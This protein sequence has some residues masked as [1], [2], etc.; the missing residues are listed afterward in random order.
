MLFDNGQPQRTVTT[1]SI[2]GTLTLAVGNHSLQLR[3]K[4]DS[5]DYGYSSAIS[6]T[7]SA[8]VPNVPP[9]ASWASPTSNITIQAAANG[10]ATLTV[11]GYGAD[12]D[13]AIVL[14]EVV[15]GSTQIAYGNG[16]S[17]NQSVN[18]AVGTHTLRVRATDNGGLSALSNAITVT[19]TPAPTNPPPVVSIVA[20]TGNKL[21]GDRVSIDVTATDD[22]SVASVEFHLVNPSNQDTVLGTVTTG[23]NNHYVYVWNTAGYATGSY[24][25]YAIARDNAGASTKSA[26]P[27]I[28]LNT[29]MGVNFVSVAPTT[30]GGDASAGGTLSA[31]IAFTVQAT[32][33]RDAVNRVELREGE[34]ILKWQTYSVSYSQ[35]AEPYPINTQRNDTLLTNLSVGDHVVYIRA[36]TEN[37]LSKNSDPFTIRVTAQNQRPTVSFIQPAGS[38]TQTSSGP[39]TFTVKGKA[40][41][42]DGTIAGI[43]LLVNGAPPTAQQ[44]PVS[45]MSGDTFEGTLTLD[46]N[47]YIVGLTATDNKGLGPLDPAFIWVNINRPP[48][49]TVTSPQVDQ[50]FKVVSGGQAS[51]RL[52]AKAESPSGSI[53]SLLVKLNGSVLAESG[54]ASFDD[55]RSLPVGDY[56]LYLEATDNVGY[57]VTKTIPFKVSVPVGVKPTV[58]LKASNNNVS[59]A[60]ASV[61]FQGSASDSDGNVVKLELFRNPGSGYEPV[62]VDT[63]TGNAASLAYSKSLTVSAGAYQFMLRATDSQGNYQDSTPVLVNIVNPANQLGGQAQGVRINTADKPELIGWAC[64][65]GVEAGINIQ[66]FANFPSST[67]GTLI[68]NAVANLAEEFDKGVFASCG[69]TTAHRFRIDLSAYTSSFAGA[70]IYAVAQNAAQTQSIVLPCADNTCTMPGSLRIALTTPADQSHYAGKADIFAKAKISNGTGSYDEVKFFFDEGQTWVD[71]VKDTEEGAYYARRTDVSGRTTPYRIQAM[72]RQGNTTLYS[73]ERQ[74]FV[75]GDASTSPIGWTSPSAGTSYQAGANIELAVTVG[76]TT[77]AVASVKFT[78]QN[79][80]SIGD[81]VFSAGA[82][83]YT[84]TAVP[85][86]TYS[87]VATAYATGG[88]EIVTSNKQLTVIPAGTGVTLANLVTPYLRNPD[89]GTL[90]GTLDSTPN[91]AATYEIPLTLPPGTGQMVPSLNLAYSSQSKNGLL[92]IGWALNGLSSI[93]RCSQSIAIDG[94]A[95]AVRFNTADRLCLDGQRLILINLPLSNA[96]Y[97]SDG[98]EYRTEREGFSRILAQVTNGKRSFK[99][100]TK[101][102]QTLFYG[103]TADSYVEGQGRADGLA[104][105]WALHHT[106]D[107]SGNAIDYEYNENASTGEH[108]PKAIRWGGNSAAGLSHY[109]KV[110]F[111]YGTD[112]DPNAE[113]PDTGIAYL[114]GSHVDQRQRLR[115]VTSFT[116]TEPDGSRGVQALQYRLAYDQSPTSYRSRLVS[117]QACDAQDNCLP[118]TQFDWGN[119]S[120]I[121]YVGLGRW[122]GPSIPLKQGAS[123]LL[124]KSFEGSISVV[125]L[126]GDGKSDIVARDG[127]FL[128][129]GSNFVKLQ[130]PATLPTLPYT[131]SGTASKIYMPIIS[132]FDGDGRPELLWPRVSWDAENERNQF[133]ILR[134][135]VNG[136][137]D[138]AT[139]GCDPE[140]NLGPEELF[141]DIVADVDGDGKSEMLLTLNGGQRCNVIGQSVTCKPWRNVD[142]IKARIMSDDIDGVWVRNNVERASSDFDG[143]GIADYMFAT[144]DLCLTG[145]DGFDCNPVSTVSPTVSGLLDTIA[146]V[147]QTSLVVDIN[148]DGYLDYPFV[149]RSQPELGTPRGICYGTGTSLDCRLTTGGLPNLNESMAFGDAFGNGAIQ[150]LYNAGTCS[151]FGD[152]FTCTEGSAPSSWFTSKPGIPNATMAGDFT[153]EGRLEMATYIGGTDD[154]HWELFTPNVDDGLDRIVRVKNGFGHEQRAK[155]ASSGAFQQ[156]QGKTYSYP[157]RPIANPGQLVSRLQFDYG[158]VSGYREHSYS[159]ADAA[160]DLSGRGSVGMASRTVQLS[161]VAMRTTEVYRQDWPYVGMLQHRTVMSDGTAL[162]ETESTFAEKVI[163]QLHGQTSFVYVASSV[164]E[165][166]DYG[167]SYV[168]KT[169]TTTKF[170][171][172]YGNPTQVDVLAVGAD[173]RQ[174]LTRTING[175][176]NDPGTWRLGVLRNVALTKQS[177]A[178]QQTRHT[179]FE[180]DSKGRLY[181]ETIEPGNVELQL[182]TVY[183]RDNPVGLIS[184][185]TQYWRDPISSKDKSRKLNETGYD[186][187]YRF[188]VWI[189]NALDHIETRT[190]DSRT[191]VQTSVTDSNNVTT[192]WDIDGFG[193]RTRE[194]RAAGTPHITETFYY[195]KQCMAACP[196]SGAN[197]VAIT[198][199]YKSTERIAVPSLVFADKLG[200]TV[201][202]QSWGFDGREIYTQS[203]FDSQD[204]VST[205]YQPFFKGETPERGSTLSYDQLNRIQKTTTYDDG[206]VGR[207][208]ITTYSGPVTAYENPLKQKKTEYRNIV[209]QLEKVELCCDNAGTVI[210]TKYD[211]DAFGNL[212]TVTDHKG[213]AVTVVYDDLGRK[214]ELRDPDLGTITYTVD[215]LGQTLKQVSPTQLAAG[216]STRM[217]FDDLGRMTARYDE[218]DLESHWVYGQVSGGCAITKSCGQVVE[219]YTGTSS[220]KDYIRTH[221]YEDLGRPKATTIKFGTDTYTSTTTYDNRGLVTQQ[222]QQRGGSAAK[223]FDFKYNELGYQ[224]RIERNGSLLW[225]STAQ[226]ASNRVVNAALGNRLQINRLF[227][228][229]SGRLFEADLTLAPDA[230]RLKEAYQYDAVGNVKQ[231][232][233][234]WD[235]GGFQELFNYDRINRLEYSEV[236]GQSSQAQTF[237][238]NEIGNIV[239]KTG[240]GTGNYVY[241]NSGGRLPHA[242]SSV[243]GVGTFTY[244]QNGNLTEGAGRTLCWN[245]FDMPRRIN[246]GGSSCDDNTGA[247]SSFVYGPEHQ[248]TRQHKSD[249]TDILYAGAMEVET[250]NGNDTV[251]TYWPAGLGVEIDEPG[252]TTKLNWTHT[253]RLGSVIG[254]SNESGDLI[255]RLAYDAWGKRRNLNGSVATDGLDGR[256]DNKGFTGHEMLDQLDLV[257]MNGRVYDPLITRFISPDP[258]IQDPEHSQSYNRYTYVWNNP[259]NLTDPTGFLAIPAFGGGAEE[260]WLGG[261]K[262]DP[263]KRDPKDLPVPDPVDGICKGNAECKKDLEGMSA[264]DVKEIRVGD[265]YVQVVREDGSSTEVNAGSGNAAPPGDI[266]KKYETAASIRAKFD[267]LPDVYKNRFQELGNQLIITK[268]SVADAFPSLTNTVARG[269]GNVTWDKIPG[270]YIDFPVA[271]AGGKSPRALVVST[272]GKYQH[273]SHDLFFHEFGHSIDR[274]GELSNRKAFRVAVSNDF[275]YRSDIRS[276]FRDS[277]SETF[278]ESFSRYAGKDQ[279]FKS[280][281]PKLFEYMNNLGACLQGGSG[282]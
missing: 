247:W 98:A 4:D 90:P 238:Y 22:V 64:E 258:L 6:V 96:N 204:R 216:K 128:S 101:G 281:W 45:Y 157:L 255:E 36:Y 41:D 49:L 123:G 127:I 75:D 52:F 202:S 169:T 118:A 249:G 97:W 147:R 265:G 260:I 160:L 87:L 207:V 94:A 179:S 263:S 183:A 2:S 215:P 253:D 109:G 243:P 53:I 3:A 148:G 124:D 198:E 173:G 105:R 266:S 235:Q 54:Y 86:G 55:T 162:E 248:R 171:D 17:V 136:R 81:A 12:T 43:Q 161:E 184:R 271:E 50:D 119:A 146:T 256:I 205:T 83:R 33:N 130:T 193:R 39:Y 210:T 188:P 195:R 177:P 233:Q 63:V 65:K 57:K 143:D 174:F 159:Y 197:Q 240:V 245:G 89:A 67:G 71:G 139:L 116:D 158:A 225:E 251:K 261:D 42:P 219:A 15:D 56:S 208:S 117:V 35:T 73:A 239:S 191:G 102:G 168:G 29:G 201:G 58:T 46:P 268:D 129:T 1:N 112:A 26:Q 77:P 47:V 103:D 138:A 224:H 114:F 5:G 122:Q 80:A 250:K 23:T 145:K 10:N 211:H 187:M 99:I 149:D 176:D 28:S 155:Y 32:S 48:T 282:C 14:T 156:S 95:G 180:Y 237:T 144:G 153:G 236:V 84:W 111:A 274:G 269:W 115:Q 19:V 178:G 134:C 189:K 79:G 30:T 272:S 69:T 120:N 175:Y 110:E 107:R 226:D 167:G 31:G 166:R 38:I 185:R 9:T 125:D 137:A 7:V 280:D 217:E 151:L 141:S 270:G 241:P 108:T 113:R 25:I 51:V 279:K 8:I 222:Q 70:P 194:I 76:A 203:E 60:S 209:G 78:Q 190:Y 16:P 164:S 126:N 93:T 133:A 242:V 244:D 170:E 206:G 11:T 228:R 214:K 200:R 72:V 154:P 106:E 88:A 196:I 182:K 21:V 232:S 85:A 267:A 223:V 140:I 131:Y 165:R 259:T 100:L 18:L 27:N 278:A 20:D 262:D 218:G 62:P 66:L 59:A 186:N 172:N 276:Y 229:Y 13:G 121:S 74:V 213:N 150:W 254:I 104:W 275:Y 227:N 82:W 40:T 163:P 221:T 199:S 234:F 273:G 24:S 264:K 192:S 181:T 68:G 142:K 92:G 246:K 230:L 257:H 91:G 277:R 212:T 44:A 37:G 61:N 34:N 220:S 231:R 252:Q 132:D 135:R 152:K